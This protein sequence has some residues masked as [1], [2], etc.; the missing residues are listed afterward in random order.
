M[1]D[2]KEANALRV[3]ACE[4]AAAIR[5]PVADGKDSGFVRVDQKLRRAAVR[6]GMAKKRGYSREF[7][8]KTE[9]RVTLTIDRI[10]PTLL[11]AAKAK[12]KRRGVS[13]RATVLRL[14]RQWI[15]EA[16]G[17]ENSAD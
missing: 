2:S 5:A 6:Y 1:S 16:S 15:G 17:S 12:A 14:L 8:P 3:A 9:R 11:D 4:L 10:P 7:T 13:L